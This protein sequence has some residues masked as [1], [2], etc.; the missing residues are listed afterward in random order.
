MIQLDVILDPREVNAFMEKAGYVPPHD[1]QR[2]LD[3]EDEKVAIIERNPFTTACLG[4]HAEGIAN[5]ILVFERPTGPDGKDR[6]RPL[7]VSLALL[8]NICAAMRAQV[9]PDQRL[10]DEPDE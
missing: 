8:E 3:P 1:L 4:D 2:K 7:L 9:G 6:P 10:I 5:V